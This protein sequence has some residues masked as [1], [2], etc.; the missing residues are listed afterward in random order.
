ML[1]FYLVDLNGKILLE[2]KITEPLTFMRSPLASND[3]RQIAFSLLGSSGEN[4]WL[5]DLRNGHLRQITVANEGDYPFHWVDVYKRQVHPRATI[6]SSI[7]AATT[8]STCTI[9]LTWFLPGRGFPAG[10]PSPAWV[11]PDILPV[12]TCTLKSAAVSVPAGEDGI[13][14]R[15]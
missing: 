8:L 7:T 13:T 10:K 11:P 1:R 14:T 9:M 15:P 2:E 3:G 12:R 6:L 5:W 4:L